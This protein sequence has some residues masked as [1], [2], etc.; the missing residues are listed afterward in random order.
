MTHP[1]DTIKALRDALTEIEKLCSLGFPHDVIQR[2]AS[3]GIA[4]T[5]LT[6]DASDQAPDA[7][8]NILAR[9]AKLE[10]FHQSDPHDYA[11][12]LA[13][14]LWRDHYQEASPDFTIQAHKWGV[15]S[16]IDNMLTGLTRKVA[17]NAARPAPVAATPAPDELLSIGATMGNVMYNLAQRQGYV[18]T[19]A[20]CEMYSDLRKKWDA[21]RRAAAS[22]APIAEVAAMPRLYRFDRLRN[23]V[24][25]AEGIG[26]HAVSMVDAEHRAKTMAHQGDKIKFRDNEPCHPARKCGMCKA[27]AAEHAKPEPVEQCTLCDGAGELD[28]SGAICPHCDRSG[29]EPVEHAKL[30]EGA[31]AT[32]KEWFGVLSENPTNEF[33]ALAYWAERAWD[34][35]KKAGQQAGAVDG[36]ASCR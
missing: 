33:A 6:A 15:M 20:D 4:D 5:A 14:V 10:D 29:K 23:G 13:Y 35:G 9:T 26:V 25:M 36:E 21:A 28:A 30:A 7:G 18:L 16:Q 27:Y 8:K 1:T 3:K 22:A 17:A 19:D 11:Q 32:F 34:A 2:R 31:D 24:V 12:F